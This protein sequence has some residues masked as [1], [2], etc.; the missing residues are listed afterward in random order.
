MPWAWSYYC[1]TEKV[2]LLSIITIDT[3]RNVKSTLLPA[4]DAGMRDLSKLTEGEQVALLIAQAHE[5][6]L[7][8]QRAGLDF[9]IPGKIVPNH[10][11]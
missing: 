8:D 2:L 1:Y 5:E 11:C 3:I 9:T 10:F 7:I 6:A 4:P